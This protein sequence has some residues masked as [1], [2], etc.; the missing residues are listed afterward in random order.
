MVLHSV[1]VLCMIKWVKLAS[2]F[3][4]TQPSVSGLSASSTC[5]WVI[6]VFQSHKGVVLTVNAIFNGLNFNVQ[7]G[8]WNK[9]AFRKLALFYGLLLM[10]LRRKIVLIPSHYH[11]FKSAN[12]RVKSLGH[13][14]SSPGGIGVCNAPRL[15]KHASLVESEQLRVVCVHLAARR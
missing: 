1:S 15:C 14:Q 12:W 7:L 2:I 9:E 13:M 11:I 5:Y 10:R 8:W 3:R 6:L 4:W